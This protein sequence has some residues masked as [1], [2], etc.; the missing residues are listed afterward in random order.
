MVSL[1]KVLNDGKTDLRQITAP[2]QIVKVGHNLGTKLTPKVHLDAQ[3]EAKQR[4][5][6]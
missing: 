6:N 4:V 3:R 2:A 5:K 1:R